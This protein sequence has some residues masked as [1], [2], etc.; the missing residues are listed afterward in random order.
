MLEPILNDLNHTLEFEKNFAFGTMFDPDWKKSLQAKING[1]KPE[2][3]STKAFKEV[4][5][6]Q[7]N[8]VVKEA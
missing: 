6:F 5:K 8:L 1:E 7:R 4:L 2:F 3:I